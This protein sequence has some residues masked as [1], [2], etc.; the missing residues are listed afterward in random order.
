M[1]DTVG[2]VHTSAVGAS[3][4]LVKHLLLGA[5]ATSAALTAIGARHDLTVDEWL[6]LD[7]LDSADGIAMSAISQQTLASGAS[8]TRAVDR[9]VT[10]SLVYR[11]PSAVDRRKVEVRI[12]ALGRE[13]HAAMRSEVQALDLALRSILAADADSVTAALA[14]VVADTAR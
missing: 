5:Q 6:I 12:S 13:R 1:S 11:A 14:Q 3:T 4:D 8:L 9:L 2:A 7:A 10:S